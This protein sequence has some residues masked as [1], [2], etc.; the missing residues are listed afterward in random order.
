MGGCVAAFKS[1]FPPFFLNIRMAD[2]V[3]VVVRAIRLSAR[4]Q[5]GFI[6]LG[7]E[8]TQK[9]KHFSGVEGSSYKYNEWIVNRKHLLRKFSNHQPSLKS[10]VILLIPSNEKS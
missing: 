3:G 6:L 4:K 5:L 9:V 7:R 10:L 8:G 1:G 2:L